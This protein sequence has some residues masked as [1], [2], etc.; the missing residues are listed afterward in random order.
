MTM[1]HARDGKHLCIVI[2]AVVVIV[3]V[4]VVV[5]V[6]VVNFVLALF[7][8]ILFFLVLQSVGN[9]QRRRELV[10]QK[11]KQAI[12]QT[13][14]KSNPTMNNRAPSM[15]PLRCRRRRKQYR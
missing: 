2:T 5:A 14:Q 11:V 10:R 15:K 6:I 4:V 7:Q 9:Q 1:R 8:D 13:T 12:N 3:V